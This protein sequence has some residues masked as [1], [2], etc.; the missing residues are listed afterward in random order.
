MDEI[1]GRS[2]IHTYQVLIERQFVPVTILD[3]CIKI[4]VRGEEDPYLY[5]TYN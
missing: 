4:S 1:L 2:F 3:T 5:K